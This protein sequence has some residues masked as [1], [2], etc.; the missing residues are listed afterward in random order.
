MSHP[1][2]KSGNALV[3]SAAFQSFKIEYFGKAA[4]AAASP[5]EGVRIW[6]LGGMKLCSYLVLDSAV[7]GHNP[8][9]AHA[10][11]TKASFETALKV[12]KELAATG[13]EVMSRKG[14]LEEIKEEWRE[15]IAKEKAAKKPCDFEGLDKAT[16]VVVSGGYAN[17]EESIS[18]FL[19]LTF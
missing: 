2:N 6:L 5:W 9:F 11:K 1:G 17:I 18:M 16:I 10:A 7:G 8:A 19:F 3:C 13:I 12:S 4:H 14:H 15:D